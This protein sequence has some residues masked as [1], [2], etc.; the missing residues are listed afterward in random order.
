[1]YPIAVIGIAATASAA[2]SIVDEGRP[3]NRTIAGSKGDRRR[4]E[5]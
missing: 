1:M 5:G 3:V 4:R 2:G